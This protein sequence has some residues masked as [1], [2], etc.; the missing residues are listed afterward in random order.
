MKLSRFATDQAKE[1]DGVW[2]DAG[3]GLRLCIA[4]VGN[5]KYNDILR[6]VSKPY[7]AQIR[8]DMLEPDI[9][10]DLTKQAVARTVLLGWENLTDDEDRQIPFTPAK[11]LEL[12][13]A[14]RDFFTMV[15]N[16]GKDAEL[17]RT[18]LQEE[19]KGNSPATSAG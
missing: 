12:F 16:L 17:F 1:R 5:S 15:F 18:Q 4:R 10:E 14:H 3:G 11:A 7:N 19:A 13:R 9:A 2:V 8:N 6:K